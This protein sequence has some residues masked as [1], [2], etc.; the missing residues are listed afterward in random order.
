VL[1]ATKSEGHA[2]GPYVTARVGLEPATIWTQG[3]VPTTPHKVTGQDP[4]G[5]AGPDSV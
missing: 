5:Q 1:Q 3:I 4:E 2:Q